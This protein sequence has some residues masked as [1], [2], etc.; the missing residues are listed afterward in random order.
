MPLLRARAERHLERFVPTEAQL[1]RVLL[2]YVANRQRRAGGDAQGAAGG[3]GDAQGTEAAGRAMV[4]QVLA[5]L[6]AVGLLDDRKVAEAW[7]GNLH[8]RGLSERSIQERLRQKGLSA[9]LREGAL[10]RV[11][12]EA[13]APELAR[14]CTYALRRRL[15]AARPEARRPDDRDE[16][17]KRREKDVAALCRAG[18]SLGIAL[19]VVDAADLEALREEAGG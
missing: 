14:A 7:A 15:G 13:E 2:R 1:R 11:E 19:R 5:D 4:E 3:E 18:F 16:A 17:R 6:R 10:A 12:A 9:P 8:R